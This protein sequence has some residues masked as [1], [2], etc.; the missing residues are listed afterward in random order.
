MN[1]DR[2]FKSPQ[3][4]GNAM[5]RAFEISIDGTG[6]SIHEI[7]L[8][9]NKQDDCMPMVGQGWT[10]LSTYSSLST[11]LLISQRSIV[12]LTLECSCSCLV[13]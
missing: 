11:P 9:M 10:S 8:S 1:I 4:N 6:K 13:S 5:Q 12:H 2:N 7:V 3:G